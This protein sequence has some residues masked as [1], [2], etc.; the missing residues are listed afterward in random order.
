MKNKN[1]LLRLWVT[2][3]LLGLIGCNDAFLEKTP[4]TS[5]TEQT[6]FV[7]Y[8]NFQA[9]SND[10]YGLF[11]NNYFGTSPNTRFQQNGTY[12][13]DFRAG[14][15]AKRNTFNPYAMQTIQNVT[16][17]NGWDFS[18][19]RTINM[20]LSHI[21][22]DNQL[23]PAERDHWRAVGYFFHSF[24][25]MELIDR[26]GDVPW[27]TKVLKETDKL[28]YG[29]RIA[30]AEVADSVMMRLKWAEE[31]IGDFQ[32]RDG[33]NAIN[34]DVIR[35]TISRFGLREGTWQKYHGLS[36]GQKY[37]DECVRASAL[38][39]KD[40]P[41]LYKGTDTSPGS[42]YGEMWTSED[43]S[44]VP[45][46]ILYK[47]FRGGDVNVTNNN[48]Y[49]EHTSSSIIEMPRHTVQLY[50]CSD[51][52]P[53]GTSP[54][55]MGDHDPYQTFRNRDPRLYQTVMPPFRVE[56][57][58]GDY[59]TWSFTDN[60]ADREYIDLMGLNE[61]CSNPGDGMKRL[62]AQNWGASLLRF[63]PNFQRGSR[64]KGTQCAP[65]CAS[66]SGYYVWK[67]YDQWEKNHNNTAF[68]TSDKPIFKIEE[69]LLNYAETMYELGRFDQKVADQT[70]NK[71]RDRVGMPS[72]KL[73]EINSSFDPN[74]DQT[75]DPVLWEIRR[76]RIIELMGEGFGFYDVRRWK[77][78]DWFIN[79][80]PLGMWVK[81]GM[82]DE[83]L[84]DPTAATSSKNNAE[85]Y[86]EL[87]PDPVKQG[88]G[89]LDKYYLYQIPTKE[90]TLNPAIKQNPGW[91]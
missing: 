46:V 1:I 68:N 73:A 42:G 70:I 8:D 53:I 61:S 24:Y 51:G 4:K 29:P 90:I 66:R 13:N 85:G 15:F 2:L 63:A 64:A 60:P 87:W 44:V 7:T 19:I 65:Y 26:F 10:L 78:A 25:Y 20:L 69:V 62:P 34:R 47:E 79:Q 27:I 28:A 35:A 72:M 14:Y 38:L 18:S 5:L 50:L 88:K 6:A 57:K 30:R 9:F 33:A 36:D 74:R 3:P 48:S 22:G 45:G 89:W 43:L 84:Y 32:K 41:T 86:I 31:H 91:E 49:I 12:N 21:D 67:N 23:T 81:K 83:D 76:E 71:L 77:K 17:G 80:H 82:V 52:K 58:K 54:L 59:P 55:Y 56:G 39:M 37:L 16:S 11:T 40:Y 75:V